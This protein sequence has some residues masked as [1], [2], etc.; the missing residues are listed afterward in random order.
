MKALIPIGGLL[1]MSVAL[2]GADLS[3]A[4]K[5]AMVAAVRQTESAMAAVPPAGVVLTEAQIHEGLAAVDVA[6]LRAEL[7]KAVTELAGGQEKLD[8]LK[9]QLFAVNEQ[10]LGRDV[11]MD[12]LAQRA[13]GGRRDPSPAMTFQ[14]KPMGLLWAFWAT[15]GPGTEMLPNQLS[16]TAKIYPDL[17]IYDQHIMRLSDWHA[18]LRTLSSLKDLLEGN[19]PLIPDEQE[20]LQKRGLRDSVIGRY[21]AATEMAEARR[22]GGYLLLEDVAP[23]IAWQVSEIP[24]FVFLSPRGIAHRVRGLH[25]DRDV[26]TWIARCLE[27]ET[28]N[29]PVLKAR[30][31]ELS[32]GKP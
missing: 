13:G 19:D 30:E 14:A 4:D 8:A 20:A 10:T 6:T 1:A 22:E 28:M 27:W 5:A 2:V 26:A 3:E 9:L 15:D 18:M 21:V 24:M 11:I 7:S 16:R 32:K 25:V 31:A 12:L 17:A 29:D 23:A